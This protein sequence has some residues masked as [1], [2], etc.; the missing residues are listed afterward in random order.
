MQ[1]CQRDFAKQFHKAWINALLGNFSHW[2]KMGCLS[3]RIITKLPL[4]VD[5]FMYK[6]YIHSWLLQHHEESYCLL[7]LSPCSA[8]W[9]FA[10]SRWQLYWCGTA[11]PWHAHSFFLRRMLIMEM[12]V[13]REQGTLRP[14]CNECYNIQLNDQHC[15]NCNQCGKNICKKYL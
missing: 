10:K 7:G 2:I 13:R 4:F 11:A 8:L 15:S 5:N 12:S 1:S 6:T 14:V 9:N 3:T